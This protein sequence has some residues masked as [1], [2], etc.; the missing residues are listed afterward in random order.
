MKTLGSHLKK[1]GLRKDL[2]M[3]LK[4]RS[5]CRVQMGRAVVRHRVKSSRRT[6]IV[7]LWFWLKREA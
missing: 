6:T 3:F 7:V 1:M 4:V 5:T 2:L